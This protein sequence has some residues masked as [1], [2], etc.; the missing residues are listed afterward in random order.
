MGAVMSNANLYMVHEG[1]VFDEGET[2]EQPEEA[3]YVVA[4]DRADAFAAAVLYDEG[5]VQPDNMIWRG[6]TIVALDARREE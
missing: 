4:E 6:Q 2:D 1:V 3:V 5:K